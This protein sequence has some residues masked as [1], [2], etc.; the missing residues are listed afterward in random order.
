MFDHARAVD[1]PEVKSFLGIVDR[2]RG[3]RDDLGAI[4]RILADARELQID[5]KALAMLTSAGTRVSEGGRFS[6]SGLV[7]ALYEEYGLLDPEEET[8]DEDKVLF[9]PSPLIKGA[10]GPDRLHCAS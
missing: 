10:R 9:E 3:S 4:L 5:E 8:A 7:R 6:V 1:I 2:L